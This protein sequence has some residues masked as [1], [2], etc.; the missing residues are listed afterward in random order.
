MS[1]SELGLVGREGEVAAVARE[2]ELVE[3]LCGIALPK[4]EPAAA[5]AAGQTDPEVVRVMGDTPGGAV[6]LLFGL[7]LHGKL[8]FGQV[9]EDDGHVT[10]A[11]EGVGDVRDAAERELITIGAKRNAASTADVGSKA[12]VVLIE[13]RSGG[14]VAFERA[15]GDIPLLDDAFEVAGDYA[16][17][18]GMEGDVIDVGSVARAGVNQRAVGGTEELDEIVVATGRNALAAL[19]HR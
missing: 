6:D 4:I 7:E 15:S 16:R 10:D 12:R 3:F 14:Q 17:A 9:D 8:V 18:G 11:R 1:D 2:L 13:S 5:T 19:A